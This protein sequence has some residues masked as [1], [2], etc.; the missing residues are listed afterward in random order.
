MSDINIS[1]VL[2]Q[3]VIQFLRTHG[4]LLCNVCH[5]TTCIPPIYIIRDLDPPVGSNCSPRH[6]LIS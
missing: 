1:V 2:M 6:T 4:V 5:P 3:C